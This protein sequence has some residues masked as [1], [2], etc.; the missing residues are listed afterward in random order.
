MSKKTRNQRKQER[1]AT[2][3]LTAIM[4]ILMAVVCSLFVNAWDSPAEQYVSGMT[5]LEAV[6]GDSYGN[7]QK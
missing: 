3:L 1:M 2:A 7:L 4:V 6:G 5:Y